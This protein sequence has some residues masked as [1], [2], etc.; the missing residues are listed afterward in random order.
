[1]LASIVG[2]TLHEEFVR[3]G[4]LLTQRRKGAKRCRASKG[5][6][7]VFASL[8]LRLCVKKLPIHESI[9]VRKID[10]LVTF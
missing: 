9:H 5:V 3:A 4:K 6:L 1:M 8:S 10:P 7:C 2:I